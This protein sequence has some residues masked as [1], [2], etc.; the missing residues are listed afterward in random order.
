MAVTGASGEGKTTLLMLLLGFYRPDSGSIL[1]DGIPLHEYDLRSA[2]ARMGFV[3]QEAS[4]LSGTLLENLRLGSPSA[5]PEQAL[6]AC[7]AAGADFAAS[8]SDLGRML[9]EG[10]FGLSLGQRQRLALA[11][12]LVGDPD[13]LLLDEPT[14]ALD[15]SSENSLLSTLPGA[16][17]ART[18][19]I[20]THSPAV[21]ELADSILVIGGSRGGSD[22]PCPAGGPR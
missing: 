16:I 12:A 22:P 13:I 6:S 10:G 4:V 1:L 2:R 20:V 19:I 11:R 14:S 5:T 21:L 9:G 17:G 18:A 8:P 3:P 15:A 7:R